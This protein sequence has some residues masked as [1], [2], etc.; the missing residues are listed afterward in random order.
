MKKHTVT[1]TPNTPTTFRF[2]IKNLNEETISYCDQTI[3]EM[4]K[5]VS[6][7]Q[8]KL[9]YM[10]NYNYL[11]KYYDKLL[12]N[13]RYFERNIIYNENKYS[14][15]FIDLIPDIQNILCNIEEKDKI[16]YHNYFRDADRILMDYFDE[17]DI[18]YFQLISW[19]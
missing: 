12:S 6:H 3:E 10:D 15:N 14:I 8:R 9:N 19:N 2:E 7:I 17:K 18:E 5:F 1:V 13:P 4:K 16:D 11:T